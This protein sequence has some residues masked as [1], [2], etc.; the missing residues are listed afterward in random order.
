MKLQRLYSYVRKAVDD[1]NMI[2]DGDRIAVGISGGKDS[3]TLLYA[4]SGMRDFYPRKFGI[5]AITVDLG[6][7]GFDLTRIQK[8]CGELNV[9][10]HIEK[11]KISEMIGEAGCSLCA[12]LR[13]GAF[14]EAAKSLACNKI[15][16]AHSMDDVV[17]TMMLSLIYEGRFSSFEP[18]T[19]YDDKGLPLIRPLIYASASEIVGF[20]N[21]Y[22]LPITKNPCPFDGNTEREYVRRLLN[23]INKHAPGVK[24]RMMT[25][26]KKGLF[27]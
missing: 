21:K 13:R 18:V 14:G 4:L 5:T 23:D 11:T 8:L 10:Y 27:D 16:Y 2:Y 17:E 9:E 20:A 3:L 25:A 15:A 19:R 7:E 26:I 1:Y 22:E 24:D 6:Y 12:R